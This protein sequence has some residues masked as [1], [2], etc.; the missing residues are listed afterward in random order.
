[1]LPILQEFKQASG[2]IVSINTFHKE[3]HMLGFHGP[4]AI[5]KALITNCNK[6]YSVEVMQGT[7][8]LTVNESKR[9]SCSD[10]PRY[11]PY[12]LDGR[13]RAWR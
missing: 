1:M 8:K 10:E 12:Q 3:V 13:V 11:N 9:V 6:R 4:A 2:T 7:S 5:H